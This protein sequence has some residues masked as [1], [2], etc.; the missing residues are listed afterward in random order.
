VDKDKRPLHGVQAAI[1]ARLP[2]I[3]TFSA[4][5]GVALLAILPPW[6]GHSG[7]VLFSAFGIMVPAY[8]AQVSMGFF[9]KR[10]ELT[11]GGRYLPE[12]RDW[13]LE[14]LTLLDP[15]LARDV[16]HFVPGDRLEAALR[17]IFLQARVI[18]PVGV[19]VSLA[20]ANLFPAV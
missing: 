1:I 4:A 3:V 9:L 6:D 11:L 15:G 19:V 2:R 16:R 17:A 7:L 18:A 5:I 20:L 8:A 14:Y 13:W 12:R 10:F